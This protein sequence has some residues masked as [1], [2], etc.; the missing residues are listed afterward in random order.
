MLKIEIRDNAHFIR[1]STSLYT[2]FSFLRVYTLKRFHCVYTSFCYGI[3]PVEHV[4]PLQWLWWV[5]SRQSTRW[6]RMQE[7]LMCVLKWL[8][9]V[10]CVSFHLPLVSFSQLQIS[11]VHIIIPGMV[12]MHRYI[13]YELVEWVICE[14]VEC[15]ICE[16]VECVICE[17]SEVS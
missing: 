7:V 17:C 14:L 11:Q 4:I 1:C 15:V 2:M 5:W 9:P 6:M 12:C 10:Q 16:L 8:Q 13:M 3:A